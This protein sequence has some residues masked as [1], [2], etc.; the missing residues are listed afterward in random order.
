M[1]TKENITQKEIAER[2]GI[3]EVTMSRWAKAGNWE[4]LKASITIT[5]QEQ[6]ARVMNQI[7]AI[8]RKISD[9]Q[10]GIPST[11]DADTLTKLAAVIERMEKETSITDVVSVSIKFLDWIRVSDIEKAKELSTLFDAFIKDL[12]K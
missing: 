3:S 12:L 11:A 9:E 4:S 1:F 8:N 6:I 7:A 10:K 5:K 2:V